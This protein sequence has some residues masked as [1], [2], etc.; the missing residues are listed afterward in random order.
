MDDH[1]TTR[2]HQDRLESIVKRLNHLSDEEVGPLVCR[3]DALREQVA[4]Y[5]REIRSRDWVLGQVRHGH[6]LSKESHEQAS[7][8]RKQYIG[9]Q[10]EAERAMREVDDT[11][12]PLQREMSELRNEKNS[13]E[14]A[15][16]TAEAVARIIGQEQEELDRLLAQRLPLEKE[17]AGALSIQAEIEIAERAL[18]ESAE[19]LSEARAELFMGDGTSTANCDAVDA[20]EGRN[21][22]ARERATNARAA[23][24]IVSQKIASAHAA[25]AAQDDEVQQARQSLL[26]LTERHATMV[27]RKEVSDAALQLCNATR[28]LT[29][30]NAEEG[31]K[32]TEA[33]R[34]KGLHVIDHDGGLLRPRWL[35]DAFD[36]RGTF[37][38]RP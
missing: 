13:V 37:Q 28:A 6:R 2:L 7:N 18:T 27:A 3:G 25:L 17:L 35:S 20:A 22:M 30:L 14:R 9:L 12:R 31:R 21:A 4:A 29:A 15:M 38:Q 5:G 19:V 24:H 8:L 10:R 1:Q 16:V 26:R 11:L 34:Y 32:L 23:S 36:G 33:L